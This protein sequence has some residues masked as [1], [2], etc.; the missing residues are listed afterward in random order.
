MRTL[1]AERGVGD[2]VSDLNRLVLLVRIEDVS[3]EV[4]HI[5]IV[6][7]RK[8]LA[9]ALGELQSTG[10]DTTASWKVL[11]FQSGGVVQDRRK[12]LL[13]S[14]QHPPMFFTRWAPNGGT[15]ETSHVQGI[16]SNRLGVVGNYPSVGVVNPMELVQRTAHDLASLVR[17]QRL[18]ELVHRPICDHAEAA[19]GAVG[20]GRGH[21]SIMQSVGMKLWLCSVAGT[22]NRCPATSPTVFNGSGAI[23][24]GE[25]GRS[26][27]SGS[28]RA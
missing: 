22:E 25:S 26:P 5:P 21:H 8:A 9:G 3:C 10:A 24:G 13:G 12:R 14:F 20:C 27:L 11:T 16:G 23:L 28:S 15:E 2:V 17:R 18:G 7:F 1:P 6:H 4:A 19:G